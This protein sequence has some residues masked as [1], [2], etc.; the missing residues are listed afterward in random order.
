VICGYFNGM[1][2]KVRDGI[3]GIHFRLGDAHSLARTIEAATAD[4][5]L[6]RSLCDGIREPHPMDVHVEHLLAMYAELSERREG[7]VAHA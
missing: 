2:E 4:A 1:A 6:W 5:R 3:D 7:A